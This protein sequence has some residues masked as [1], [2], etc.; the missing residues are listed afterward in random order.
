[1]NAS[2]VPQ[3]PLDNTADVI[4]KTFLSLTFEWNGADSV[5]SNA[6]SVYLMVL[7]TSDTSSNEEERVLGLVSEL[8]FTVFVTIMM[9]PRSSLAFDLLRESPRK[10]KAL[11]LM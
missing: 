1:M 9:N 2:I 3:T 8:A 7:K 10:R 4:E 11:N 6:S 5:S